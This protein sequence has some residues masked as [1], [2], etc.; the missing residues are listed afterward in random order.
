MAEYNLPD[1]RIGFAY[2]VE[3][4]L[5]DNFLTVNESIRA[6]LRKYRGQVVADAT[7]ASSLTG[8]KINLDLTA[9]ETADLTPGEYITELVIYDTTDPNVPETAIP[10]TYKLQADYSPSA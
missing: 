3:L 5:P 8:S 10:D 6:K 4:D 2:G 9:L 7:F 1:L